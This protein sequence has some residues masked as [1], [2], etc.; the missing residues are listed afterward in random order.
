MKECA[1][2]GRT[3]VLVEIMSAHWLCRVSQAAITGTRCQL[4]M[5]EAGAQL[6]QAIGAVPV[7]ARRDYERREDELAVQPDA[8]PTSFTAGL[9][10]KREKPKEELSSSTSRRPRR[11]RKLE[12]QAHGPLFN[13][14]NWDEA[15]RAST[16]P[17]PQKR[18]RSLARWACLG[19]EHEA[20]ARRQRPRK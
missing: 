13:Q 16:S 7:L 20:H 3:E 14:A 18:P 5:D 11:R 17:R 2:A 6:Y 10:K 4:I 9:E 19:S 12:L 15:E 1:A 8:W